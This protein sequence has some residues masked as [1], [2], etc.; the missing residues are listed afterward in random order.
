MRRIIQDIIDKHKCGAIQGDLAI[1]IED[2]MVRAGYGKRKP[3]WEPAD[4]NK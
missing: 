1:A 4:V 2:A 3:D